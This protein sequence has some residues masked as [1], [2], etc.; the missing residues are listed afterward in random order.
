MSAA[1]ANNSFEFL[2]R[3]KKSKHVFAFFKRSCRQDACAPGIN[4]IFF[5]L[6]L[7]GSLQKLLASYWP[8]CTKGKVGRTLA[9]LE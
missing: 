7:C 9:H 1:S 3:G 8:R 6:H 2:Q 5:A 4:A